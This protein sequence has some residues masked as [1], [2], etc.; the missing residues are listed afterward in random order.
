MKLINK[1]KIIIS[2]FIL[3][4]IILVMYFNLSHNGVMLSENE[5][6]NIDSAKYINFEK[7]VD[8]N[9]HKSYR[10]VE[11]IGGIKINL[12]RPFGISKYEEKFVGERWYSFFRDK[13]TGEILRGLE[14]YNFIN[15][16]V[17]YI[18]LDK[19]EIPNER[20]TKKGFQNYVLN[21]T[22]CVLSRT[23]RINSPE[24]HF[25]K[26]KNI[27]NGIY[28]CKDNLYDMPI[29]LVADNLWGNGKEYSNCYDIYNLEDLKSKNYKLPTI[30]LSENEW[31]LNILRNCFGYI[32][33][34]FYELNN[35]NRICFDEIN[36]TEVVIGD[37]GVYGDEKTG[38]N[39]GI[40][41]G[42]D[43]NF[44]PIFSISASENIYKILDEAK[45]YKDI[46]EGY[47]LLH[48]EKL[49][50]ETNNVFNS[51]Y[52]TYLPFDIDNNTNKKN[53][54]I[55]DISLYNERIE[56][57][58]DK[59][60]YI[61]GNEDLNEKILSERINRIQN[62]EKLAETIRQHNQIDLSE[63]QI[64]DISTMYMIN[65]TNTYQ[66]Q[67]YL[68]E[69]KQN[70]NSN[71]IEREKNIGINTNKVFN[72][73]D[74]Y[75]NLDDESINEQLLD[76]E[77]ID[78]IND[79]IDKYSNDILNNN[80]DNLY[81][82]FGQG[83][84]NKILKSYLQRYT[85]KTNEEKQVEMIEKFK[86]YGDDFSQEQLEIAYKNAYDE[87]KELVIKNKDKLKNINDEELR[88]WYY[89]IGGISELELR[90]IKRFL[91]ENRNI[92]DEK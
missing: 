43:V 54:I 57:Y 45:K 85:R 59:E 65:E 64:K 24:T 21:W 32:G 63:Y 6:I 87:L 46:E 69:Y 49:N 30:E 48:I 56:Y 50:A 39:I 79:I 40:C 23:N 17:P 4:I 31:I 37:I 41:V 10:E 9:K 7:Y 74:Y 2:I 60:K 72:L 61:S 53:F 15:V 3:T 90:F 8:D 36:I 47:N 58:I 44:N 35:N 86:N 38:Y 28:E 76:K 55:K 92:L 89:S 75:N 13:N 34:N 19:L 81:L 16:G 73:S 5:N 52:R 78:L 12:N 71:N 51:Y 91:N 80:F 27:Y 62:R 33:D 25:D 22:G 18:G 20:K 66:Y 26:Y 42:Y 1:I 82:K 83:F 68:G 77:N 11:Y 67:K 29:D 88:N 84:V 14:I 70:T